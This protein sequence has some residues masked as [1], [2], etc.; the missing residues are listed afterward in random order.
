MVFE[1]FLLAAGPSLFRTDV[2]DVRGVWKGVRDPCVRSQDLSKQSNLN[3][4]TGR[5]SAMQTHTQ[6]V[7]I[8]ISL[9]TIYLPRAAA[10]V[11]APTPNTAWPGQAP[12]P[13]V[14]PFLE[15]LRPSR[16]NRRPW[17]AAVL[18][19]RQTHLEIC[20]LEMC[21]ALCLRRGV[22]EVRAEHELCVLSRF[23][24]GLLGSVCCSCGETNTKL[25]TNM[26]QMSS[27]GMSHLTSLMTEQFIIMC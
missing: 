9:V 27:H 1:F 17:A 5:N 14:L 13:A 7:Q 6:L 4:T 26:G 22:E 10:E 15:P 24:V 2:R 8:V 20:R 23:P 25:V 11:T 12:V 3:T 16:L 18:T 19:E 21:S